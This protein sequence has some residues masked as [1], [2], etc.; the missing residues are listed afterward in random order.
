[1]INRKEISIFTVLCILNFL[2][3]N[4]AVVGS[5]LAILELTFV[6]F[7]LIIVKSI[8]KT[9]YW[10][11]IFMLSSVE[12]FI[13]SVNYNE[14]IY[15]YKHFQLPALPISL[16]TMLTIL[17][18]L[19]SI[20]KNRKLFIV[21]NDI[22]YKF[23]L[24]C[25][26]MSLITGIVGLIVRD[27]EAK[28]FL[29][30]IMIPLIDL[31]IYSLMFNYRNEED[32]KKFSELLISVLV[33]SV[34]ASYIGGLLGVRASYGA[35]GLTTLPTN[36][37][38]IFSPFLI[39]FSLYYKGL[40]KIFLFV[41]GALACINIITFN[42]SGKGIIFVIFSCLLL[43]SKM[44]TNYKRIIGFVFTI[45]LIG[46]FT[47]LMFS[48]ISDKFQNN[49]LFNDKYNQVITLINVSNWGVDFQNISKSPRVRIIETKNILLTLKENYIDLLIGRGFGGYFED[50]SNL[51]Y[52]INL[53]DGVFSNE[54]ILT[55]RYIRPHESWNT[56]LLMNGFLGIIIWI[57]ILISLIK[58]LIKNN[59]KSIY[60]IVAFLFFSLM[61]NTYVILSC[62]GLICLYVT[63]YGDASSEANIK[64]G[65]NKTSR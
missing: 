11:M 62:F 5:I 9:F 41:I 38:M 10:H 1:M 58:D 37:I 22:V 52:N 12:T 46:I 19:L 24:I 63:K 48:F 64:I 65:E 42:A 21:K 47:T 14:I 39:C 33:G 27:Y 60:K 8:K 31:C 54:E 53:Y 50:K 29:K 18:F 2:F 61:W 20:I 35:A 40:N 43:L 26:S 4:H 51:F 36:Q 45:M 55:G 23:I 56:I 32:I 44:V 28:N 13:D 57:G 59:I 16:S 3:Y 17:L 34:I 6:I 15:T 25:F 30:S 49:N 7:H